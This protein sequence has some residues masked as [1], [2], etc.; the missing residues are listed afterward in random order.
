MRRIVI[1]GISGGSGKTLLS[2]GL[3]RALVRRGLSVAPFKKGPDYIDAAWLAQAAKRPCTNLDLFFLS[4]EQLLSL[5]SRA[6]AG[7]D[8]AVIEGNRGLYDGCDAEGSCS[9]AALARLLNAPVLL[10]LDCTK[11]TRTAAALLHGLTTFEPLDFAGVVLAQVRRESRHEQILR[12]SIEQHAKI[13]VLGTLPRLH[14]NPIPERHMGLVEASGQEVHTLLDDLADVISDG[15]D[16]DALL[17]A[18]AVPPLQEVPSVRERVCTLPVR[19][20][21]GYVH[22]EILWFYYPENLEALRRAG[23]DLVPLKLLSEPSWPEIDGL[24]LG[25][26]FP[27]LF[28]EQLSAS[29]VLARLAQLSRDGLPIYAECGGFMVLCEAMIVNG[30]RYPMAGAIPAC[31]RFCTTPQGLGY[32]EATADTPNP[33]Y[34]EGTRLRGHEFHY[35]RCLDGNGAQTVLALQKGTGM[36]KADSVSRDG[37]LVRNTFASYMH[38]FAPAVPLWAERLVAL[39]LQGKGRE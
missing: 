38:I 9:T 17:R 19:P 14:P 34:P 18:S 26:G 36:G 32:V 10:S 16:L 31:A 6:A 2:L 7:A 1:S 35:S 12:Q 33:F 25:G 39:C 13:P 5:F 28:A 24:Y 15:L 21:I 11:T 20:R 37:F 22:D 3:V 23:A 8:I 4:Q 27:E 30:K 29:P